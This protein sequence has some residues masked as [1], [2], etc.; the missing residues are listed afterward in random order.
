MPRGYAPS[1]VDD[2]QKTIIQLWRSMGASVLLLHTVGKGCPDCLVG[3]NTHNVLV[4]IKDGRKVP[5]KQ[6]LTLAEE[7]FFCQWKGQVCIISDEGQAIELI[8]TMGKW[9]ALK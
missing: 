2:N 4:E 1:R 9:D 3:Y 7:E 8:D 6:R 5:S